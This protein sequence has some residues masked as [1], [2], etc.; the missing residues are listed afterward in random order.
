MASTPE[1]SGAN[2]DELMHEAISQANFRMGRDN[3][4]KRNRLY[5]TLSEEGRR[6]NA[7]LDLRED[8]TNPGEV[9][10]DGFLNLGA[11]RD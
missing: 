5:G 7:M 11:P 3:I 9:D 2:F 6:R 1:W 8:T 10:A 4:L